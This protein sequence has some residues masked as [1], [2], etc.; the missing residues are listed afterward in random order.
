MI[1]RGQ[2][3]S[4]PAADPGAGPAALTRGAPLEEP[5]TIGLEEELIL[6]DA[7]TLEPVEEA[8]W[9]VAALD[10]PRFVAE[11]RA[12]QLELVMPV[13]HSVG[14]LCAELA[15][16]R[17][18][19]VGLLAGSVRAL[20][21]GTHP[22]SS[23]PVRVTDRP[24]Y[25]QIAREYRWATRRG[26]PSG[27]HVHV[28]IASPGEALAVYNAAR[29]YLP[30][31]AALA[32]NSPFFEGADT[33]LA[34]T[35][36]KLTE[37]FPRSRTPPPFA[38]WDEFDRFVAWGTQGGLFP[39]LT[40]LW[41]DL[42]LRPDYG[43]LEFRIADSQTSLDHVAAV[44]AICQT[45]VV[46]LRTRFEAGERLSTHASHLID[47]NR[48]LALRDGLDAEL[49]DLADGTVEPARDR[50]TR[51]VLELEPY[52]D[53]IGCGDELARAWPLIAEN[54]AGRQRTIAAEH[55]LDG[56]LAWLVDQTE[57]PG[58]PATAL[59]RLLL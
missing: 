32:A 5:L 35:R 37:D 47:E 13:S 28:G 6:V 20:A 4:D 55:G 44:A 36:L 42:R 16:A 17:A 51:L 40:Q 11:F 49:V 53:Q 48:W 57:R 46:A 15:D 38:S 27:L 56:L 50:L 19:L 52:A 9:V 34:S 59:D 58:I 39:D 41:W 30:E 1:E 43:T 12:A 23:T 2:W 29:S 22:S 24:R 45:L 26:L 33:G 21:A 31:L 3:M 54:G 8:E 10:D 7:D 18:R 14:G 25:E